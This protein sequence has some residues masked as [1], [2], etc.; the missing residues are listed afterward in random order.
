MICTWNIKD[1]FIKTEKNETGANEQ[2]KNI[3][4]AIKD[5]KN[6]VKSLEKETTLATFENV[7]EPQKLTFYI[8]IGSFASDDLEGAKISFSLEFVLV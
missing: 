4:V 8:W 7:N 3:F 6:A 1:I 2:R 5:T